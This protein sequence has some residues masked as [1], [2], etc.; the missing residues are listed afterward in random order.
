MAQHQKSHFRLATAARFFRK[1][2]AACGML[3]AA[4]TLTAGCLDR[5]VTP[6]TPETTNVYISQI[7]QTG[8]DKIDLLFMIDNSPSMGDKQQILAQA[9]PVLVERLITPSC[10][11]MNANPVGDGSTADPTTGL[12]AQGVAE[13]KPIRDIHVGIVT[14]SL[15]DHGSNDVCSDAE[16]A[17][18][19]PPNS[20]FYNDLAQLLP[21][22]RPAA[23]LYS[24]NSSGFLVW[25]PRNQ[26]DVLDPHTPITPNETDEKTFVSN[27]TTQVTATTERGCGFEAQLEAWYRFLVDP[28]PVAKM[29]NDQAQGGVNS[30]RPKAPDGTTIVNN[31][32]L[33]QRKAFLRPDSL[34]AVLMLSDE[35]DCS[36]LDEDGTQGWLVGYKGGVGQND[37][38]MPR[39]N[40]R[41]ANANDPCC[42]PCTTPTPKGSN[43]PDNAQDPECMKG[44]T[45]S[46]LE[47]AL[48]ER[49][50]QTVK[51]FGVDLLYP[52]GRYVEGLSSRFIVPRLDGHQVPNPIYA[53]PKGEPARDSSLVFLAGLI[54]V[55]WQDISTAASWQGRGLEYLTAQELVDEQRWP[56]IL[57]DPGNNVPP[58]DP[59][60]LE[61]I[62][63]RPAG[64]AN[65]L[66][67]SIQIVPPPQHG[68]T[69]MN[70][71]NGHEQAVP[72]RDDLQ[73]ACI[74]D[75]GTPVSPAEC[76]QDPDA[77]DCTAD[78]YSKFS[79]L[80]QGLT[81]TADGTQVKAKGYPGVRELEVLKDFGANSIVA[82]ICPKNIVAQGSPQSDAAYGYN[83][84]VAAIVERLKTAL[85]VKCLP[86]PLAP[87][88][89]GPDVGKVPCAVVEVRPQTQDSTGAFT[90]CPDP[91]CSD[92]GRL[93]LTGQRTEVVGVAAQY[94]HDEGL[95]SNGPGA[96]PCE[97]KCYCELNQFTGDDLRACETMSDPG[98]L[99]GYC[100][101]DPAAAAAASPDDTALLQGEQ[102]LVADCLPTQKRILRF[103]GDGVPA[104][105]GLAFIACIGATASD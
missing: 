41:C 77:C 35:N 9:V 10:V 66:I 86:R 89:T 80:C 4:G 97:R 21:S 30:V 48:N 82:S 68:E 16:N 23:N 32:V 99:Y 83:P 29:S 71:I 53:A 44:N 39:A 84:A 96:F 18:N 91:N 12:C 15:G 59:F 22:V 11:D 33:A 20:A 38:R 76:E 57:G 60:M 1:S 87:A 55:P 2:L 74:F 79:P 61:Q 69:T 31:V 81:P 34:L 73:F 72:N 46:V 102:T 67:P 95:C 36:V 40:S 5:P 98:T 64:A 54:G 93:P 7:R 3:A 78:S 27:F 47:D 52:T 43:C 63:P 101:V 92:P 103:M 14:S 56:V 62:D 6:A 75:L 24:W 37:W 85:T 70:A 19:T 88:T 58:T 51:R 25:D 90:G 100:Y 105:D 50:L 28:E 13:F 45:L 104:K 26:Q 8:V 94:L 65:P 49:C 17:Q 42:R